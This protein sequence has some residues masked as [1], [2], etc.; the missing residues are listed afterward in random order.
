LRIVTHSEN[1]L[2]GYQRR[3]KQKKWY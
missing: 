1:C 2:A 3:N